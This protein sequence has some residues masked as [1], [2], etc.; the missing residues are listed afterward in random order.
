MVFGTWYR[1]R[2]RERARAEGLEEGKKAGLE[3]G[4]KIGR[5]QGLHEQHERWLR[6][7]DRRQQ[8]EANGMPFDEPPPSP[9]EEHPTEE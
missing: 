8:A 7:L 4:Q 2:T 3:E 9:N 5:Q 6:W 1:Q